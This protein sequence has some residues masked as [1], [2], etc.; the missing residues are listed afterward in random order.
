MKNVQLLNEI[1]HQD[2]R[3]SLEPSVELGDDQGA[4]MA[5]P[6]EFHQLSREFPI[7]FRP[8]ESGVQQAFAITGFD[9]EENLFLVDGVWKGRATPSVLA[10]GPF[11]LGLQKNSEPVVSV[12]LDHPK[13]AGGG[14]VFLENGGNSPLLNTAI[15]A[16]NNIHDGVALASAMYEQFEKQG[17]FE[18]VELEFEISEGHTQRMTGFFAITEA[19]LN[20]LSKEALYD[21]N[22]NGFLQ[23]AFN[24][25]LS[26][27]NFDRLISLKRERLNF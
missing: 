18:S 3:V 11:L 24:V 4:F 26:L 8:N 12:D 14:R 17:L 25:N 10:K 15:S 27:Q 5:F 22:Q 2:L 23:A 9:G 21:L 19:R 20:V 6:T 16:L 1:E 7:L 13:A